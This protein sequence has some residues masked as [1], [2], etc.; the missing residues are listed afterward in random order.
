MS[1]KGNLRFRNIDSP[2]TDTTLSS[3]R[4]MYVTYYICRSQRKESAY[5]SL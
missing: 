4:M 5:E 2:E 3:E 1:K